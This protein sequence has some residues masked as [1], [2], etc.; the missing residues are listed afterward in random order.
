MLVNPLELEQIGEVTVVRL[1]VNRLLDG[2]QVEALGQELLRLAADPGRA[3]L[4]LDFGAVECLSSAVLHSL[5]LLHQHLRERG[6]RLA[7][8]NLRPDV[9]EVFALAGLEELLK[10]CANERRALLSLC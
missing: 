2:P 3:R 8:C 4:L 6:G 9:Q 7:L 1:A 5:L 10:V